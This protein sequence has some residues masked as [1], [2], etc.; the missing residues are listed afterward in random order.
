[1]WKNFYF[2]LF[3]ILL[4]IAGNFVYAEGE[5]EKE[6]INPEYFINLDK[7]T[8]DRG[9][10]VSA[11]DDSLKLSLIPGTLNQATGVEMIEINDDMEMPW[12]LDK[13]SRIYQFEF[14]NKNAYDNHKPF[15]IQFSYG[16]ET[17]NYKQVFFYDK[18]YSTWRPLPTQDFLEEKFVRSLIHLPFARLAVLSYPDVLTV[19]RASWYGYKGGNFAASPDFPSES[20]LRVYNRENNKFVDVVVNDYG[21]DRKLHPGRVVDLDKVAFKKLA[22][23][24]EGVVDV[25]IE[26]LYIAPDANKRI[27]GFS[28]RGATIE[29]VITSKS[30]VVFEE[31]G[32][33]ILFNKSATTTLPL[34][35][36]TKL[37][38]VKVF[39]DT[40]PSL[41]KVVAY[42]KKDEEYNYEYC[43][44]WESA[45]LELD[46][47]DTLTIEDLVYSSLVGSANN[48]IET[49]VRVSG[50]SRDDFIKEMNEVAAGWGAVA[51]KFIEP[52]GLSPEN[53]SSSLDYAII[54]KEVFKNPIIQKASVSLEYEFYTINTNKRHKLRNTNQL[55]GLNKYNIVGSKTGYLDEAGYCLMT[56]VGLGSKFITTVI[57]GAGSRDIS[58]YETEE[59][60][61]YG[62]R[63]K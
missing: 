2:I 17:N 42:D 29:P 63:K 22:S 13:I 19:G 16:Q 14:K 35:S 31:D 47:G 56:R 60:I 45:R 9:Y 55:I 5:T 51:T 52:T 61:R 6:I 26:P 27:L 21:P 40:R 15:Y 7:N 12:N 30:A 41:N 48:T 49:L 62:L 28:A 1:M 43:R 59:L 23:L 50:L 53:V 33:T 57:M 8:V 46:D 39:L 32:Q 4:V 36:L 37:V 58:F 38:A 25:R 18:N 34:A 20:R 11:F 3:V 10:T 54:T 24:S 44:Q